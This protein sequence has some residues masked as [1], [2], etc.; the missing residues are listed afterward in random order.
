MFIYQTSLLNRP[1]PCVEEAGRGGHKFSPLIRTLSISHLGSPR[2]GHSDGSWERVALQEQPSLYP[3]VF[4]NSSGSSISSGHLL[5][6]QWIKSNSD[7]ILSKP[8]IKILVAALPPV[9][10]VGAVFEFTIPFTE[11]FVF[12][13]PDAVRLRLWDYGVTHR[14][15][16]TTSPESLRAS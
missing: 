5:H 1:Q 11:A 13:S 6:T 9:F 2:H 10:A 8:L 14:N 4:G 12:V 3:A 7:S 16:P 15:L